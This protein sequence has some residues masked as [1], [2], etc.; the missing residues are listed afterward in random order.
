MKW[1]W[2]AWHAGNS[3]LWVKIAHHPAVSPAYSHVSYFQAV[4]SG[5]AKCCFQF[6]LYLTA[7]LPCAVELFKY[8]FFLFFSVLSK[9]PRQQSC[10]SILKVWGTE[11]WSCLASGILQVTGVLSTPSHLLFFRS[12]QPLRKW[13]GGKSWHFGNKQLKSKR[14]KLKIIPSTTFF[15]RVEP[16]AK[17][18]VCVWYL[19]H[20]T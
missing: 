3:G 6:W 18:G 15:G 19:P 17:R 9:W 14:K 8:F 16:D 10:H 2:P 7:L 1:P 4:I 11:A 12:W 20:A 13:F 5:S